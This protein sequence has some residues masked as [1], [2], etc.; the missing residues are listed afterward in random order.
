MPAARQLTPHKAGIEDGNRGDM[1]VTLPDLFKLKPYYEDQ[2]VKLYHADCYAVN[3]PT[4]DLL[5]TDPPYELCATGGGIGAKR[6]YLADID[7]EMDDGFDMEM[8]TDFPNWAVF[9]GKSQLQRLLA[10][11]GSRRWALVTWNKTNPTPLVNANYLPDTEYIV[12]AF[13]SGRL[14]G[15]YSDRSRFIV[16]P[17]EKNGFDHPTVKPLSVVSKMV[18]LGCQPME[19]ILDPFCGTGTTLVAA[20]MSGRRAI[21]IERE[22]KHCET[23]ANR[24]A[25]DYLEL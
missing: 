4:C 21:G 20:K 14:F 16:H 12:H 9:C 1:K 24:C 23:A 8:L 11:T 19:T 22:R 7:G 5:L 25:Q 3:L 2:W 15:E 18:R 10:A 13:Q 17:V 6:K